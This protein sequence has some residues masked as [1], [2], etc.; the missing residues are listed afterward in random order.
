MERFL[1]VYA[2]EDEAMTVEPV[3]LPITYASHEAFRNDLMMLV[4]E[5]KAEYDAWQ[6]LAAPYRKALQENMMA[7]FKGAPR[8]HTDE[9]LERLKPSGP[10]VTGTFMLCGRE[11]HWKHFFGEEWGQGYVETSP[12]LYTV[13]EYF[14]VFGIAPASAGGRFK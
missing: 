12:K 2:W 1:A 9:A 4:R 14:D 11:F 10:E 5:A 6:H 8:V 3:V 7:D 13:E